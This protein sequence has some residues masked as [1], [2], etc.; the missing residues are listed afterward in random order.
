MTD[1]TNLNCCSFDQ[2]TNIF[3]ISLVRSIK[4]REHIQ[5]E[6]VRV[7]IDRYRFLDAYDKNS[8]EVTEVYN[9]CFVKKYPP[10]FRCGQETCD[11]PNKSLFRPQIGNWLSHINAWQKI[12]RL[13][14]GLSLVC[15]DDVKFLDN[16]HQSLIMLTRSEKLI[17]KLKTSE[18][19]LVR[20]GWALC[21]EHAISSAPRLTQDIK[22]ANPCYAINSTMAKLVLDSLNEISTTSD[23]FLH[24]LI[25]STVNHF[26]VMPPP[27][28]ELSW[29]T[30][31]M[32]SE[33][34]PKEKRVNFLLTQLQGLDL[35]DPSH[36]EIKL[37][38]ER[39]LARL[40]QFDRYNESPT[41][42]YEDEHPLI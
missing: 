42:S 3:C 5:R 34:R 25:G 24:Q 4:R 38:Y 36:S 23:V 7:G 21:D 8:K 41:T 32:K 11:C 9:S 12:S 35:Q 22:M 2:F 39:E 28:Y 1:S 13:G 29:S 30:G 37:T 19:V 40:K 20:L 6:F 33:I 26:T 10:C 14:H 18:P 15:E 17:Q 27:A 31:E 16:I